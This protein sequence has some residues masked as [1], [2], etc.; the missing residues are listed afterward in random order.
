MDPLLGMSA[1][2]LNAFL[3]SSSHVEGGL[4]VRLQG[5][6]FEMSSWIFV[7]D[8]RMSLYGS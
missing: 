6:Q 3:N 2:L 5:I 4:K 8:N 7:M 1:S